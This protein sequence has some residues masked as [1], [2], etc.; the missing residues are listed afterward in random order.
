[1]KKILLS[2]AALLP[3]IGVAHPAQ[4]ARPGDKIPNSYIC[5]FKDGTVSR[6]NA[7]AEAKRA[8][9]SVRG[10]LKLVYSAVLRG[11]AVEASEQAVANMKAQ[12]SRIVAC[13]QDMIVRAS[14]AGAPTPPF[15]G[16]GNQPAQQTPWGIARVNGGGAGNFKTAW[17]I[18]GGIELNHPD[19]NVDVARSRSF[20]DTNPSP[21]DQNGHGTH[22][23]GIIAAKDNAIGVIGVAPGAPVVAVRVLDANGDG[24]LHSIMGGIDYVARN[25]QPG[26][27]AN[28]SFN[29][30]QT[31][32]LDTMVTLAG[33]QTGIRFVMGSGN[34]ADDANK[35]SPGRANGVNLYTVSAFGFGDQF[36][37]LSN[38]GNPPVDYSE[39]GVVVI[40]T[41]IGNAYRE[42]TGTSMAAPHLSG[43]LLAGPVRSGG[44][45][46][47]DPDG[48]PDVIGVR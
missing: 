18:D 31:Y 22:V 5:I 15:G 25:G 6:G 20:L 40:S 2:A 38:R 43:I 1:M 36:A 34:E 12:D 42:D 7:N 19:L 48:I 24:Y 16:P 8:V 29:T 44:T 47:A 13:E 30:P 45:V 9:D 35:Y 4:A 46:N 27:V 11:F 32:I 37:Y 21:N 39:P 14:Q 28:L 26:D 33:A 3:L 41:W 17:V 23:A 10:K